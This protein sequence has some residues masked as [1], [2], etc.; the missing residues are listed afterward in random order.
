MALDIVSKYRSGLIAVFLIVF[1]SGAWGLP[2]VY[3]KP[4]DFLR[5]SFGKIP[6]TRG[7]SLTQSQQSR[8]R[9]ILGKNYHQKVIRYWA[10][11]ERCAFILEAVGKTELITTGYVIDQGKIESVKVLVYRESHGSEVA[12]SFFTHQ[13]RGRSL[14]SDNR[15]DQQPRNIAGATLSVRALTKMARLALYLETLR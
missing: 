4:S 10:S 11:N 2:Q 14:G 3:Q 8:V 15:L 13:F 6:P 7:I 5:S 1:Q 12:R 9:S